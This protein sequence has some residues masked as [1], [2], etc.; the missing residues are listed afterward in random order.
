[1]LNQTLQRFCIRMVHGSMPIKSTS[2]ADDR[3]AGAAMAVEPV[4]GE[5]RGLSDGAE[6]QT[7]MVEPENSCQK[8]LGHDRN[9]VM[10][11]ARRLT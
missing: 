11:G 3:L 4:S 2:I 6:P 7:E 8:K 9:V 1:M 5:T 10:Y